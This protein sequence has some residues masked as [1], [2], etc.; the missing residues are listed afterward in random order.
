MPSAT[1]ASLTFPCFL[2]SAVHDRAAFQLVERNI[3]D[4][5]NSVR[6]CALLEP[7]EILFI[8]HPVPASHN[9]TL[10][11]VSSSRTLPGQS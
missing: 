5:P 1:D 10:D 7:G 4:S 8:E 3:G 9:R 2:S 11:Y 6:S